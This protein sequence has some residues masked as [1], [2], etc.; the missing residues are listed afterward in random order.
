[1][2][3]SLLLILAAVMPLSCLGWGTVGH[4]TVI[5]VAERHISEKTKAQIAR[6]FD[7]DIKEDAVW[8]DKHRKDAP[9]AYTTA[10]HVY[11]VD[12]NH[13]YDPSP[14]AYKGDCIK[15]LRDAVWC[16]EDYRNLTDSAVVMNVRMLIHFAGDMHCP[17]HSYFPGPRNFWNCSI[18]SIGWKGQFHHLYDQIPQLLYPNS[19]PEEIAAH[20]D[21][22]SKKEIKKIQAGTLEDW[23][24]SA[25]GINVGIYDINAP[26]TE[27][28]DSDTVEKSHKIVD[29]EMRNAGY[30]LARLLEE[31]FGK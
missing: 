30:R 5:A 7:Y 27:K 31:I 25:A 15:G 22:C 21:N 29:I 26:L 28:L 23:A 11:N 8:M 16:L 13:R 12:S 6:Y 9:I 10:W 19:T 18:E 4:K 1:M 20:I 17:V 3:K 14:R 2:K 24:R